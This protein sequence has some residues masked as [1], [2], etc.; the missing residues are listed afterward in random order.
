MGEVG[1]DISGYHSKSVEEF[2]GQ[3]FDYVLTVCDNA[4]ESC[5]VLPG[6]AVV[7]HRSFEDPAAIE[8]TDDARLGE[9]RRMRDS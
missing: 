5:P 4:K 6:K 2:T 7:I 1:V 9:F 3:S 8:D